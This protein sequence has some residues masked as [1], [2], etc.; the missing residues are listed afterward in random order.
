M[1]ADTVER[2]LTQHLSMSNAR[3]NEQCSLSINNKQST[4]CATE[5][6]DPKKIKLATREVSKHSVHIP[7]SPQPP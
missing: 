5:I 4:R 3:L 2:S 6:P 7:Q 1:N